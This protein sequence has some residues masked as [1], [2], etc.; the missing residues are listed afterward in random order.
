MGK[1]PGQLEAEIEALRHETDAILEELRRRATPSH[2]VHE[3]TSGVTEGA[4]RLVNEEVPREVRRNRL[5]L[6]AA[7]MAVVAGIS[8]FAL[9][10]GLLALRGVRPQ[11]DI[12]ARPGATETIAKIGEDVSR[13]LARA[14]KG[15]KPA[16]VAHTFTIIGLDLNAPVPVVPR[17]KKF[18]TETFQFVTGN[19]GIYGWQC[20]AP[21]GTGSSGWDGPMVTPGWMMGNVVVGR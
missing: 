20:Y 2:I 1:T 16:D 10:S 9:S 11:E 7:G 6:G 18:I 12:E 13:T 8:A 14:I 15:V 19:P 3:V 21:C 5:L 4:N 17:G